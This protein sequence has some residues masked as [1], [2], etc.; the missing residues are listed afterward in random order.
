MRKIL[1]VDDE[2]LLS[3]QGFEARQL[4]SQCPGI[5]RVTRADD[6]AIIL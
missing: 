3:T 1:L 5:T 4:E 2:S 6:G